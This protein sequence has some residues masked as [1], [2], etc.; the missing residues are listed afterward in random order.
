MNIHSDNGYQCCGKTMHSRASL[1]YHI[2]TYHILKCPMCE[3]HFSETLELHEH[4]EEH[5]MN[6]T[7]N[8]AETSGSIEP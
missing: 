7:K 2:K 6:K 3:K 1:K 5:E 8:E 4:L